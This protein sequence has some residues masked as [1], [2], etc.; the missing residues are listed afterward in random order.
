MDNVLVAILA[1]AVGFA[2]NKAMEFI[3]SN[4]QYKKGFIEGYRSGLKE[5]KHLDFKIHTKFDPIK[6]MIFSNHT[7]VPD[8]PDIDSHVMD[9]HRNREMLE[10]HQRITL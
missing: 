1:F 2:V 4:V 5:M 9:L 8:S 10:I 6:S 7:Y 3:G